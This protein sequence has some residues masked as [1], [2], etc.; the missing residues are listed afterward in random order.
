MKR[1]LILTALMLIA[2]VGTQAQTLDKVLSKHFEAV[3]Q[4]KLLKVETFI[5]K[6]KISQMGMDLPMDMIIV[7]PNKFRLDMDMQGQK[8]VQAFD[9]ETGWM[10]MPWISNEPQD[11]AGDQLKQAM[12]QADMEGELY[13][14]DEKGHTA[15][16]I[17]KVNSD[18]KEAYRIKLTTKDG[19]EKNYFIDAN[20]Y[21]VLKVKAKVEA[22]G[23]TI[24]VET[25]MLDYMTV[26]GIKMAKKIEASSPMGAQ[27]IVFDEIK[28]DEKVD[29]AIFARPAK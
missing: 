21:M 10:I 15:E 28:L 20:S 24:D 2:F 5:M 25:K 27:T 6:A 12:S 13:N 8:M 14:Y 17:G 18:G 23:Q 3:G 16:L 7:R 22:M 29:D 11:L 4:E 9:G 19:S 1:T 26:N